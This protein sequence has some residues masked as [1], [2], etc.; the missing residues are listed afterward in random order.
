MPY[1]RKGSKKWIVSY[2]V[3]GQKEPVKEYFDSKRQAEAREF[4]VKAVKKLNPEALA[5]Q[6]S[7]ELT[8]RQLAEAY[9]KGKQIAATTLAADLYTLDLYPYPVFGDKIV[10]DITHDDLTA[11]LK[12]A[13]KRGYSGTALRVWERVRAILR[14]GKRKKIITKDPGE[15]FVVER[16][17]ENRR[18][19]H[20]R[21]RKWKLFWT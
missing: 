20:P 19:S 12:T 11:M 6:P 17:K 10:E 21:A 18:P 4:E 16:E 8:F 7:S 14:W 2:R 3:P 1:R 13:Y 9:H 5:P 15:D